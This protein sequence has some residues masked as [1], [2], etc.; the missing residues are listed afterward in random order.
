MSNAPFNTLQSRRDVSETTALLSDSQVESAG[1]AYDGLGGSETISPQNGLRKLKGVAKLVDSSASSTSQ[2]SVPGT[3]GG[4]TS[5]THNDPGQS[6]SLWSSVLNSTSMRL[7][8]TGS[9]A[10]DH[11]ASE[12]TFLA[13]IRTSLA[14][15]SSGVGL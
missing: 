1:R 6:T 3:P 15:A 12:R 13:Y 7:E 4:P 8:N 14:I 2:G 9:V 11:L 10:R 5:K